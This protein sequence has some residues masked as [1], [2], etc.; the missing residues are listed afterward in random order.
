MTA[1]VSPQS[2]SERDPSGTP[3]T[4]VL[5]TALLVSFGV[6]MLII[7]AAYLQDIRLLSELPEL[8]WAFVCGTSGADGTL[9]PLFVVL[10]I[11]AFG[12]A[13]LLWVAYSLRRRSRARLAYALVISVLGMVIGGILLAR[14]AA[15]AESLATATP[16]PVPGFTVLSTP[17]SVQNFA[18]PAST[19]R[20]MRLSDFSGRYTLLFFGYTHCPDICPLTL[21]EVRRVVEQL[22]DTLPLNVLFI[23]VDGG[24]DTPEVLAQYISRFSP[25]FVGMSGDPVT[26]AQ[27]SIDY[28]LSY[29]LEAPDVQGNYAV[30]HSTPVFVIDPQGQL[31]AVIG[32]GTTAQQMAEGL[33]QIA[34][35]AS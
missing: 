17:R 35:S 25:S 28:A 21:F 15:T 8:V 13:G 20:I 31:T 18:L 4:L 30:E 2:V 10:S 9:L 27:L 5:A 16:V 22:G 7:S 32:F 19:G 1:T 34:G 3:L 29:R 24:R 12:A 6:G 33:L 11:A 23:S 14:S 26:L